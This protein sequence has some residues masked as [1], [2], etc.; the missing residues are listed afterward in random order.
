MNES[1]LIHRDAISGLCRAWRVR[2][3]ELFGSALEASWR[4]DSDLDL[5]VEFEP[6][7]RWDLMD[8]SRFRDDF[9]KLVGRPV[10]V[11]ERKAL[12]NPYRRRHI[13]SRVEVLY[14]A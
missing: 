5:L 14:A 3:L 4:P 1:L 10:D 13:L 9:S 2:R 11:V 6:D 7:A 8:L 12:T